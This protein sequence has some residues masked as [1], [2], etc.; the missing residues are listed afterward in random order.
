MIVN[1]SGVTEYVERLLNV[2]AEG[3]VG[4]SQIADFLRVCRYVQGLVTG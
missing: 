2:N 4:A 3:D 1:M